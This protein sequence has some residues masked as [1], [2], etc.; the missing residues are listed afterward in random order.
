MCLI[1]YWCIDQC[2]IP[3][4]WSKQ[5][6]SF[7]RCIAH[8][9]PSRIPALRKGCEDRRQIPTGMLCSVTEIKSRQLVLC[10]RPQSLATWACFFISPPTNTATLIPTL[11][12]INLLSHAGLLLQRISKLGLCDVPAGSHPNFC[13][14]SPK[15]TACQREHHRTWRRPNLHLIVQGHWE[16]DHVPGA[17]GNTASQGEVWTQ[18]HGIC[19]P[20]IKKP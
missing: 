9:F 7:F 11:T 18:C 5:K 17:L 3:L 14:D 4:F 1:G 6:C 13:L 15:L 8:I 10:S 2:L 19:Q 16:G 12:W 20:H